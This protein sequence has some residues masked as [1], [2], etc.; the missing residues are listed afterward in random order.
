MA[1]VTRVEHVMVDG[2]NDQAKI[3]KLVMV[4]FVGPLPPFFSSTWFS[5]QGR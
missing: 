5:F 4:I 3:K 2:W 1:L